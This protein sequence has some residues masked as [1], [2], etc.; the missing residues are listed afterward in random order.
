MQK[1]IFLLPLAAALM[2]TPSIAGVADAVP[3]F[4]IARNCKAETADASGTGETLASCSKDEEQAKK[5][6]TEQ[7]DRF[8]G[9]DKA[10][11]IRATSAD[12]TP[13]YV[14]LRICLDMSADNR[15]RLK[16]VEQPR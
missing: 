13:S 8:A 7:W 16:G 1:S 14:E 9:T 5:E 12:G 4:D 15:A 2:N 11:C 6:L 3:K 10:S